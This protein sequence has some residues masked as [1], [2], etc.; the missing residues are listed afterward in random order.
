VKIHEQTYHGMEFHFQ[1]LKIVLTIY[2]LHHAS[3]SISSHVSAPQMTAQIAIVMISVNLCNFERSILGSSISLKNSA[4]VSFGFNFTVLLNNPTRTQKLLL[5]IYPCTKINLHGNNNHEQGDGQRR[6]FVASTPDYSILII[7]LPKQH[8]FQ[9]GAK[10]FMFI[11]L[12]P[13][14]IPL[15]WKNFLV[16]CV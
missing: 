7:N 1:V 14:V 4:I 2:T 11:F 13:R 16:Y 5:K 8:A 10:F 3:I 9:F 15:P 6:A 12:P